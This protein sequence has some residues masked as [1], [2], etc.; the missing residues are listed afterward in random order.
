ML[1]NEAAENESATLSAYFEEINL[2]IYDSSLIIIHLKKCVKFFK[3]KKIL[4]I[5]CEIF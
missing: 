3:K 5:F 1:L 2:L 4:I